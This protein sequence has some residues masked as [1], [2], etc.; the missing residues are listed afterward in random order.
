MKLHLNRTCF[1]ASL[2]SQ[3]GMSSFCL[4]CERTLT[5]ITSSAATSSLQKPSLIPELECYQRQ[6]SKEFRKNI[7][8]NLYVG[9]HLLQEYC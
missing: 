6:K 4:S 9:F 8:L 5:N 2:K 1:H 7:N 3:T